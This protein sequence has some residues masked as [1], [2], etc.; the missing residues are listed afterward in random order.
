LKSEPDTYSWNDLELEKV[1]TWDGVRNHRAKL[2]LKSM[3]CGDFAFFYH[4]VSEKAVVGL[5][6]IIQEAFPDP[7]AGEGQPWVAVR[8]KPVARLNRPV[9]LQELKADPSMAGL[10]LLSHTRLSVMPLSKAHFDAIFA[11]A[12]QPDP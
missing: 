1:G 2:N 9:T 8:V 4:S 3:R 6:E 11:L 10:M 7:T 5:V 12:Q